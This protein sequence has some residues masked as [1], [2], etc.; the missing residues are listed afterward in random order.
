MKPADETDEALVARSMAGDQ[1][2][3]SALARRHG[4]RLARVAR[5]A[6]VA[7]SEVEDVVQAAFLAGWRALADFDP[8]R[9]FVAWLTAIAVNKARDWSRSQRSR[10]SW[11]KAEPL[12]T[13]E[14]QTV[15]DLNAGPKHL[16]ERE[17]LRR[18]RLAVD[19]LEDRQRTALLL[20]T[21][22]G[23]TYPEAAETLGLT[24]KTVQTRVA[25]AR[26]N[27]E[28]TLQSRT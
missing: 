21:V 26:R 20:V 10:R 3:F 2:A 7:P 9:S 5:A 28:K 1:A 4:P 17:E 12:D 11:F 24:L 27:L 13:P 18:V 6:G 15:A 23:L 14:A 19:A 25:R 22:G 8:A 16:E